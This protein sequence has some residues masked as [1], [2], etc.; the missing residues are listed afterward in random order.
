MLHADGAGVGAPPPSR[1]EER[2]GRLAE[3]QQSSGERRHDAQSLTF[4]A[5]WGGVIGVCIVGSFSRQ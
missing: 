1:D 5:D 2:S 4:V 3:R